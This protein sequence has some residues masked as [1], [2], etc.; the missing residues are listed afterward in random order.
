MLFF[1]LPRGFTWRDAKPRTQFLI[2]LLGIC[3]GGLLIETFYAPHYPAPITGLLI[4]FVMMAMRKLMNWRVGQRATGLFL[5]RALPIILL[6]SLAFRAA[7]GPLKIPVKRFY[8][9]A[10]DQ[11]GPS[12]FGRKRIEH[13][14]MQLP[15]QH[16]VIVRYRREHDP[17]EEWVYNS[18]DIDSSKVVWAREL[19]AGQNQDLLKH[20][21]FRKIWLLEAD[22]RPPRLS[23][24][25]PSA[26]S[27][28]KPD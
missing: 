1:S 14:L 19:S 26:L 22:E 21:N 15:G 2:A 3:I 18:A 5:A 11:L 6:V 13:Q 27:Q 28:R 8:A 12:G 24:Y 20:F 25:L 10:W 4:L 9:P 17:F 23:E 16:L 7:A